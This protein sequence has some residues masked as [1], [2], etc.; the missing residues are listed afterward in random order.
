M[1][2]RT[3]LRVQTSGALKELST[4]YINE[5]VANIYWQF[6]SNPSCTLTVVGSG[7]E[8]GS[9]S[10]TRYKAGAYSTS[11]TAY[12][13]EATTQEPQVVTTNFARISREYQTVNLTANPDNINY[14]VY[15]DAGNLKA[16]SLQDMYDTFIEPAIDLLVAGD[17]IY[18]ISTSSTKSGYTRVSSTSLFND[19]R[20]GGTTYTYGSNTASNI[21]QPTTINNNYLFK[22]NNGSSAYTHAP[23]KLTADGD[24]VQME[25]ADWNTVTENLVRYAARNVTGLRIRWYWNGS[26]ANSGSIADTRLNGSGDYGTRFVNANDYRAQEFPNGSAVTNQT[27]VLRVR[28]V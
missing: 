22:R 27:H 23:A 14:P 1:A 19:T 21:D 15:Y 28:K 16:M 24:V 4:T 13:S 10:D 17:D 8:M 20:W 26:G 5:I 6:I 9:I 3:P 18:S 11:K 7:G 12:P 25:Q 2:V